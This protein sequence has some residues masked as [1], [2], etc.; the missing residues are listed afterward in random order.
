MHNHF[1]RQNDQKFFATSFHDRR[2]V[3]P[4]TSGKLHLASSN[5]IGPM[6]PLHPDFIRDHELP[7]TDT[8][9]HC[10]VELK[11]AM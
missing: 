8:S 11:T 5:Q 10:L 2:E 7:S 6:P 1:R 4:L 9:R 3:V